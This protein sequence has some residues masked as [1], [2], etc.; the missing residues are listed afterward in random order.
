MACRR[1]PSP[2]LSTYQCVPDPA[3]QT[4]T[5]RCL[6]GCAPDDT[7]SKCRS[8]LSKSWAKE[9]LRGWWR[10]SDPSGARALLGSGGEVTGKLEGDEKS[11]C[12]DKQWRAKQAQCTNGYESDMAQLD[13]LVTDPFRA[14]MAKLKASPTSVFVDN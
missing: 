12:I 6:D 3:R 14:G 5:V 13:D 7:S 9:T 1:S 2:V 11:E 4:E 10:R 8:I